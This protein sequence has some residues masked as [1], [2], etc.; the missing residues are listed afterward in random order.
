MESYELFISAE[1]LY[2]QNKFEEAI[3]ELQSTLLSSDDA[4]L[5][6]MNN[7]LG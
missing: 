2:E 7:N 5:A 3:S 6:E 1:S 4:S